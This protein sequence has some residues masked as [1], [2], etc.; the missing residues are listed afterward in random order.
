M[1]LTPIECK[2][3]LKKLKIKTLNINLISKN[4]SIIIFNK[5]FENNNNYNGSLFSEYEL[6]GM[7]NLILKPKPQNVLATVRKG[8]SGCFNPLQLNALEYFNISNVTYEHTYKNKNSS[9]MLNR[10][11]GWLKFFIIVIK[12]L[13]KFYYNSLK[14]K[15]FII[16]NLENLKKIR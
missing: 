11:I 7:S 12:T 2:I 3:L 9:G 16:L 14:H 4:L 15:I 5:I 1:P 8:L 6:I 13:M 10:K